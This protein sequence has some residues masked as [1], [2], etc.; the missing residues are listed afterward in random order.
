M[1]IEIKNLRI[2]GIFS[3]AGAGKTSLSEAILYNAVMTNRLG[4]VDEGNTVS[5]YSFDEIARK[6]SINTSLLY[7]DYKD[8][9]MQFLDTPGY[10]DFIGEVISSLRVIDSAIVVIDATSGVE[11]GTERVWEM[12]EEKKLARL[13]FINK[14]DKE[15]ASFSRTLKNIEDTFGAKCLPLTIPQGEAENFKGVLNVLEAQEE[16]VNKFREKITETA[17]EADD[18]ILEKYLE[19]GELTPVETKEAIRKAVIAG[20]LIPVL[21]GSALNNLGVKELMEAVLDY[22]PSPSDIVSIEGKNINGEVIKRKISLE[23][24]LSGFVFK[25]I[26]DPYVGQLNLFRLYSG[27]LNANTGFYNA[28]KKI[29]ERVGALY[30]LQGKTQ[31]P[32]PQ[33]SAGMLG[34][35]AKLK[36]TF[37]SDSISDEKEVIIFEPI[38][39]PETSLSFAVKP[40]ARTDE[41]KISSGL[42]RLAGEDLTFK[43]SR[44]P[45]TKELIISGMGDLHLEV[46]VQRLK[47]R[48][49][50]EVEIGTPKVPYKE[51]ITRTAQVQGKYK[52]QSGGR[53]QYGDCW[54]RLEPL[55]RGKG[56]EFVDEIFGGAV[57]RQYIPAVEKGVIQA[58]SEGVLAGY[59]LVDMKVTIYDGSYHSVDS[60]DLAFQIAGAMALR[61]GAL[62]AGPVLLEPIMDVEVVVPEEYMGQISGDLNA[63]RGRIQGVDV[64]GKNQVIRVQVPLAEMFRYATDLRSMTQGRGFYTMRFSHYEEVPAKIA[65]RVISQAKPKEEK[66]E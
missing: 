11:V 34:A 40:K 30:I 3:H 65:E 63:R 60:S 10:A 19:K 23:E 31:V 56:F 32:V 53:G 15:N 62:E 13:I 50:V 20:K 25:T 54:L 45:Q 58:M 48:F 35:V 57:P 41:E 38:V 17:A 47:E 66:E 55:P 22:L 14:M 26:I 59:P 18:T 24:P 9:R 33:V 8:V 29:K 5:D 43:V 36:D 37:T 21:C 46:M 28:T 1:D 39:F 16:M 52:R 6:V 7:A 61:K 49:G 4:K 42:S 12:L 64:R 51:T 2:F 27:V 44:D